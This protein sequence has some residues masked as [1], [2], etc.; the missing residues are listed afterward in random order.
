MRTGCGLCVAVAVLV[1]L[2]LSWAPGVEAGVTTRWRDAKEQPT[3]N[4][5]Y[6][7]VKQCYPPGSRLPFGGIA[8]PDTC[9]EGCGN[10]FERD[11][12]ICVRRCYASHEMIGDIKEAPVGGTCLVFCRDPEPKEMARPSDE[13]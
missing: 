6:G 13:L 5:H 2:Q 1:L 12:K 8:G 7:C 3:P 4:E 10:Q 9:L 11:G